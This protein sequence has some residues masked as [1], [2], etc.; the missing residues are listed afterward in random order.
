MAIK[1]HKHYAW[2]LSTVVAVVSASIGGSIIYINNQQDENLSRSQAMADATDRGAA[3]KIA[4][5]RALSSTYALAAMVRQGQ[6]KL[7]DFNSMAH[8][9]IGYYPGVMSLQLAPNGVVK[10]IYPLTGNEKAIGHNLLK[11]PT[12]NKEAFVARDSGHMTLAGPFPLLQG[13]IGAVGRL[14][15][16]LSKPS[17]STSTFWGFSIALI[18]FP[19]VLQNAGL[20]WLIKHNYDYRLWRIHPDTQKIQLIASSDSSRG[21][22]TTPVRYPVNMPNGTWMLDVQPV[23]GW[24]NYQHLL[25]NIALDLL[26]SLLLGWMTWQ[27]IELRRHRAEL[28][29]L[30]EERTTALNSETYRQATLLQTSL[31]GIYI[32]DEKGTLTEFS[33][34]FAQMLGYTPTEMTHMNAM[35]W[36]RQLRSSELPDII[37]KGLNQSWRYESTHRCKDGTF[38]DVEINAKGIEINGQRYLYSSARNITDR[39]QSEQ[40]LRVAATA[41]ESQEGMVVTDSHT[42]I[43]NV[44]KSFTRITGFNREEAIGQKIGFLKSGHHDP[45]FYQQL[46]KSIQDIGSWQGEIWNRRKS[47]VLYPEWLS[48]SAVKDNQNNITHY[49][50]TMS[51]ITLRKEAEE[52]IRQLAFYDPLTQLPNRRLLIDRLN[53]ALLGSARRQ[54]A[55]ALLFIDLDNFKTLNDTLGHDMGDELL[56][57]VA[58]RLNLSVRESDT[59]ARLGGD[60]FI[61]M[62]E[63]LSQIAEE[64]TKQ[65]RQIGE[66][67]VATIGQTYSL[68][69][70][71]HHSTCSMGAVIFMGKHSSVDDLLKQADLAMY[72]AKAAGRNTLRF[73]D[74]H[75][76]QTISEKAELEFQLRHALEQNEFELHYQPQVNSTGH[77]TGAEALLRWNRPG[78]GLTGPS[79]FIS[80][81]EESGLIIPIGEWVLRSACQVLA[82]WAN[83]PYM[84]SLELSVNVSPRQF[85]QDNFVDTVKHILEQTGARPTHLKL[86]LTESMLLQDIDDIISRVNTLKSMGISF[87]LDDFGTGYSSLSYLRQL[88]LD[89]L[90]ID[91]SFLHDINGNNTSIIRTIIT[92][93]RS[94]HLHVIAEGVETPTQHQFLLQQQCMSFQGYLFG[95]PQTLTSFTQQVNQQQEQTSHAPASPGQAAVPVSDSGSKNNR[96]DTSIDIGTN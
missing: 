10:D 35:I 83:N 21:M 63:G 61:I 54:Q 59:V 33:P 95:K 50:G 77:I 57:I 70:G 28:A 74:P 44:N 26:I 5:D 76:Q 85:H 42:T 7:D 25:S 79:H 46:W 15:I 55:G 72:Q 69:N 67:I 60:E 32:I 43:L 41:F 45:L 51:D 16:Y 9:L 23:N 68:S 93:A 18:R 80:F 62:L 96:K 81:A 39:K 30:V 89:Q 4:V 78:Y 84:S 1:R 58:H 52:K 82:E 86:E 8:Q 31:D 47:G 73:F 19:G 27:M 49:V 91:Q 14:P 29:E 48:I 2:L 64:A 53:K 90:K 36:D 66:N 22:L 65:V 13:G 40:L 3:I 34:S 87:A 20:D 71:T 37:Q 56:Q 6:G 24:H 92:L 88:P 17:K 12:R 75:M 38:I 94:M 11:D